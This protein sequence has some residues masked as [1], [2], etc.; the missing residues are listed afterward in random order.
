MP[1]G[2]ITPE[3]RERIIATLRET[4]NV[5]ETARRHGRG[6]S[7]VS[8]IG[9]AEGLEVAARAMTKNATR[10]REA[11]AKALRSQ[12]NVGLLE[13]ARRLRAQLWQ[14]VVEKKAVV[15]S[16]G[17]G[18]G[19][20]IEIAEVDLDEPTFADKQRIITAVAIAIDKSVAIER[21][22]DTGDEDLS[23]VA[24]FSDWMMGD[25]AA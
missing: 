9:R 24:A 4:E 22:D 23:D 18:M 25:T 13:D 10:A 20:S 3:E 7:T 11:D 6:E 19:S 12:L 2:R 16:G 1:S 5:R 14:P 17:Q 21:H 15:V 8:R